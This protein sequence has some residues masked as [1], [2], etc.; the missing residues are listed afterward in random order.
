MVEPAAG[1]PSWRGQGDGS[2]LPSPQLATPAD[3][4]PEVAAL[5]QTFWRYMLGEGEE[6]AGSVDDQRRWESEPAQRSLEELAAAVVDGPADIDRVSAAYAI[7]R[8]QTA[9][10]VETLIDLLSH[11]VEAARRASNYG[12][13]HDHLWNLD[14]CASER[15]QQR[16]CGQG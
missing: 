3:R 4:P 10:A 1:A 14:C 8:M 13:S 6:R 16:S 2:P 9:E 12:N 5:H 15:S 7:G 11:P